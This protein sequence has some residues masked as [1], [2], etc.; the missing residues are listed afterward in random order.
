MIYD[1]E[2]KTQSEWHQY[3]IRHAI[4]QAEVFKKKEIVL[5]IHNEDDMYLLSSALSIVFHDREDVDIYF[6][7]KEVN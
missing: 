3:L 1:K 5:Q 4:T 7:I 2:F 6:E